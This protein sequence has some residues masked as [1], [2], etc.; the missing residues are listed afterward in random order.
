MELFDVIQKRRS[1][2]VYDTQKIVEKEKLDQ[3]LEY[4]NLAP[5]ANQGYEIVVVEEKFLLDQI[6]QVSSGQKIPVTAP[7]ALVFCANE[8]RSSEIFGARG[9]ELYAIQDAAIAAAYAQLAAVNLGLATVWVGSFKEAEVKKIIQAPD[10]IRPVA[11]LSLGYPAEH[12]A[13]SIRRQISD[14]VHR[15]Q[16]K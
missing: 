14:I 15:D 11:I 6:W 9:K 1:V 10:P 5:S 16:F 4:T 12:P 3:I 8:K 2:R 13:R 7:L